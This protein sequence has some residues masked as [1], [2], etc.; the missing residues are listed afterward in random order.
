MTG[1]FPYFHA[2]HPQVVNETMQQTHRGEHSGRTYKY[3]RLCGFC[4][5]ALRQIEHVGAAIGMHSGYDNLHA[6]RD[7]PDDSVYTG[8]RRPHGKQKRY[9]L[10]FRYFV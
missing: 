6:M 2:E 9:P 10:G 8:T 1:P 4:L 5:I 7:V 3:E